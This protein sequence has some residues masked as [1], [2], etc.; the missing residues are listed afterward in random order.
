[1]KFPCPTSEKEQLQLAVC[2]RLI[3]KNCYA[4]QQEIRRD[5]QRHGFETISQS[6]VSRLL[7]LL[8]V[9]KIRNAKGQ[10]IYALN[11]LTRPEPDAARSIAEMV[12]NI[13][14]NNEFI[15]VH[16]VTGYGHAVARVLDHHAVPQILGVVAG[17]S[18]VW[19]APHDIKYTEQVYRKIN[20]L[21]RL[22]EY[23]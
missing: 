23:S 1:M 11:P 12:V 9:I 4:S 17:S 6:T 18:V 14:H 10:K 5:L 8:G 21:L 19:I 13:E 2:L 3:G 15:L 16:T 7:T 20:Y 22:N